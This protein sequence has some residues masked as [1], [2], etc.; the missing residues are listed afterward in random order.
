M[1]SY[2][3]IDS[4]E[5]SNVLTNQLEAIGQWLIQ[6]SLFMHQSKTECVLFGTNPRV[7][8]AKFCVI[9]NGKALKRVTEYKYLGVILD[10]SL[11]WKEHIK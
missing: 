6:N 1:Q 3:L 11:S 4:P 5:I 10:E 2:T 7:T 9:V 8:S